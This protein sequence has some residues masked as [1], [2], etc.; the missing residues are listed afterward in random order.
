MASLRVSRMGARDVRRVAE[1]AQRYFPRAHMTEHEIRRRA[2]SGSIFFVA[3]AGRRV[4]GFVD[5]KIMRAYALISGI[6]V[7]E[8][9][10]G[11]GVGSKLLERALAHAR[12]SGK[13][14]VKLVAK[15]S[16]ARA[17]KFYLRHG[18][19]LSSIRHG[20]SGEV[21][22]FLKGFEN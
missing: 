5:V 13:R 22:T 2:A 1:L 18:F 17:I 4:V 11:I 3:R 16:N 20:E 9:Y 8:K 21:Y 12:L 10:E 19:V 14:H 6:A 7:E 15:A